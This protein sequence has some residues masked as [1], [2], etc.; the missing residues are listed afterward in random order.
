VAESGESVVAG[1][2]TPIT[3]EQVRQTL[4]KYNV[5][6]KKVEHTTRTDRPEYT[7]E[8]AS[9]AD[10]ISKTLQ[11]GLALRDNNELV[12]R[13]DFVGPQVGAQLRNQGVLAVLY[14]LLLILLYVAVRFDLFFSPGAVLAT[15][16]DV[17]ITMGVFSLFQFEFNLTVVAAILT[18]IG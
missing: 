5:Q 17:I 7:V 2:E 1:F 8:L 16:H 18:L 10:N 14:S 3:E 4:A 6:I 15:L 9:L 13:V 11:T 12:K